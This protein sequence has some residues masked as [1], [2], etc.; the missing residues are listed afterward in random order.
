[1]LNHWNIF[2]RAAARSCGCCLPLVLLFVGVSLR[3][4]TSTPPVMKPEEARALILVQFAE[5]T[6][7]PKD[8]REGGNGKLIIGFY[9]A[10]ELQAATAKVID[11]STG[12]Y[13]VREVAEPAEALRCHVLYFRRTDSGARSL[14]KA[15]ADKPVLTVGEEETFVRSDGIVGFKL[16]ESAGVARPRYFV[17]IDAMDR[18]KV[19][20]DS[21][22][23][24][25]ALAWRKEQP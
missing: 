17:N 12:R 3:A 22:V 7:W 14:L 16:V 15:V 20:L 18:A 4:Q 19:R 6:T 2:L 21:R 11:G 10:P 1:M 24:G 25:R 23:L 8:A 9:C 5:L 13:E